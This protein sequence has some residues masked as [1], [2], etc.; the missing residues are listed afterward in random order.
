MRQRDHHQLTERINKV[1]CLVRHGFAEEADQAARFAALFLGGVIDED[2]EGMSTENLYGEVACLWR[3]FRQRRAGGAKVRVFNPDPEEDGWQ[4]THTVI[5]IVN[6]DMPFLVDSVV[7]ALNALGIPVLLLIHPVVHVT[8]DDDGVQTAMDSGLAESVLHVEITQQPGDRHREIVERLH[9]VLGQVRAAVEDWRPMVV[10]LERHMAAL[11]ATPPAV[12]AG[13]LEE[14]RAFLHWLL[15]DHFTFLGY[16]EYRFERRDGGVFAHIVEE[17]NRGILREISE[18][19]RKRHEQALPE[20][21]VQYLES[22]ELFIISKAWT[23]SDVHRAVFMDYIGLRRFNEAGEVVGEFRFLGLLTS[24]AYSTSPSQIPLLRRKVAMVMERSGATPG[25]HNAKALEHILD[26]FPRDE[27]FQIDV[28]TLESFARGILHLEHRQRIRL[29]L[30]RDS[31]GQFVSC[32]VYIPR[33]RYSTALR[34]RMEA[35]LLEELNGSSVDVQTQVSEAPMARAHFIVHTPDKDSIDSEPGSIERR[36]TAASRTWDDDLQDALTEEC[37]EGRGAVLF[38][39]YRPGIPGG[40]KEL[41]STRLAVADIQRMEAMGDSDIAMNLYRRVD[42]ADGDLNFK[43]YHRGTAVPLSGIMPMLEHMGMVVIEEAPYEI[44]PDDGT[45]IWIHDFRVQL[46]H[47]WQVDVAEVR[48]R[49][50]ETFARVWSGAIEDDNFNDLVLIGLDWRQV[51]ILR[52]YAKFLTQINAPFSQAYVAQTMA[53]N[54]AI[55][56]LLVDFFETRFDPDRQAGAHG[57]ANTLRERILEALEGVESL[58]QDRILRRYL[59]LVESTL[60]TNFYQTDADGAAR[61]CV[62]F[63]FDSQA[64]HAL[65]E[66]RP[67]R[68]IFVYS[69][70]FEA[71]HLRGG[72]VARGGIRWSDRL[73]DFRTEVLG[74]VKAQMV[75]NA[76]IVPVGSKGGFV[77]KNPLPDNAGRDALQTEGIACYRA[78]MAAMLDVTDNI[79]GGDVVT[80]ERL[81]RYDGDDP[82]LVVAADKG[83]A[84]FSDIAN[85]VA[86]GYGHWLGDAFASGGSAGYDHKAMAITAKGAW[87]AVRRHFR[88]IGRDVD[89]VDF[90]VIGI[91]DMMGDVFGNGMLMSR[92]IRL[93]GAFNHMHIF[94]DPDPDAETGWQERKR[95]FDLPRSTWGDYRTAC[96]SEGGAIYERSAKSVSLSPQGRKALGIDEETLTPAELIQA[97]L[98]ADVDLLWNGGIG[99]YIKAA[100]EDHAGV[101]DRANDGVRVNGREVGARVVGEGGN[102]GATQAGRIEYALAGGRINT[103]AIDNSGGVDCS[104]HEVNI[105]IL[106][107]DIVAAGDMTVKQRDRLLERMTGE[108]AGLVLRSNYL[109]TQALSVAEAQ[110][111]A[112]TDDL[113]RLM[114]ALENKGLLDRSIEGLPDDE[115]LGEWRSRGRHF[116]RPELSVL[117]AW[118]KMDLYAELLASDLPD[119]PDLQGDLMTYFPVLLRRGHRERILEH[120]LRREIVATF[121]TNSIINRGG[122]TFVRQL[123]EETGHDFADIARA[124]TVARD[125]FSLREIWIGIETL[126]NQVPARV[127]SAMLNETILLIERVTAWMLRHRQHPMA[128]GETTRSF[129]PQVMALKDNLPD[130]VSKRRR[131]SIGRAYRRFCKEGVPD[132]IALPVANLRTLASACD[133]IETANVMG[134]GVIDAAT[135]FFEVG[136]TLDIDWMRDALARL[137]VD[138]RWDR[139]AQQALVEDS[140][141]RQRRIS[142]AVLATGEPAPSATGRWIRENQARVTRAGAI[143]NDLK[144]TDSPG[145]FAM[146]SVAARTLA[147][148]AQ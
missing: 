139:L 27:L 78:F 6:D 104:D 39:R 13:E 143:M 105:K 134:I 71:V 15:D 87:E 41:F 145:S 127:Q 57:P 68:E 106:L 77:V 38:H 84:T 88:E 7:A 73:E 114:R 31:Y 96:L 108:V 16:R 42:A 137:P 122:I 116:T 111:A 28:E 74:L 48:Q 36:L 19:S 64:I 110:G 142:L 65:P 11:E 129:R 1:V 22:T 79:S 55:V 86:A 35:I 119:D 126:D 43:V 70:R 146:A 9:H 60:R 54:P 141:L 69:T 4:S 120:R 30:R 102:L 103:D 125:S 147:S 49:F 131:A 5:E 37:G 24:T 72:P 56:R 44:H 93:I 99:T 58:D 90:T 95:L 101:G 82:Y 98:K 53:A 128:I 47:G 14:A 25:S 66:P 138:S 3:F 29:F 109:Q 124:Y 52:A 83:T 2:I 92:H 20:H 121:T 144:S 18:E 113:V 123:A 8:R 118:A 148:L 63:K 133:V 94:I 89:S 135:V 117:L 91:G 67:W 81:V 46:E 17:E 62:S 12:S 50:H 21:F 136:E 51:V 59:N 97:M 112:L 76:V 34:R 140:Y 130:L 85:D 115:E 75:K 33:E 132:D 26:T 107:G 23:R 10:C 40:Y 100:H 61:S 45:V 80:R 32:L